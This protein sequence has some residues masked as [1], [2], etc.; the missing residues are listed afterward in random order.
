MSRPLQEDLLVTE[1]MGSTILIVPF[2]YWFV[3]QSV[4]VVEAIEDVSV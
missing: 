2:A 1:L 3:A 4:V